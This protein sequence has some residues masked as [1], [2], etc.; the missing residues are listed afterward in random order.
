M[1][2]AEAPG[3]PDGHE[4]LEPEERGSLLAAID[5]SLRVGKRHQ[6][7]GWTQG[8][9]QCVLPHEILLCA[10][11]MAD[12]NAMQVLRFSSTRYFTD[13]HLS[14][15]SNPDTG[16]LPAMIEH[17]GASG[18]PCLLSRDH[19]SGG[20][21]GWVEL[22]ERHELRN[23][24]GYGM[25][26]ADGSVKSYFCFSRIPRPLSSRTAYLLQLLVPF[27]DSTLSR[28]LA[29]EEREGGAR[30]ELSITLREIEILRCIKQGRTNIEIAQQLGI[31]INTVKNHVRKV[32][33]KLQ[34]Q[35]R[36]EAAVKAIQLGIL[37]LHRR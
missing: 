2:Q 1:K 21:P 17:W 6:F 25:R 7:F 24:A 19:V 23:A 36:G 34:V 18:E 3:L 14:A 10:I 12:G 32:L 5:A 37:N 29:Y 4:T 16:I 28:V 33:F 26:A 35:T 30:V 31:S 11:A 27:L 8:L 13:E 15:V 20:D 9:L 22:V